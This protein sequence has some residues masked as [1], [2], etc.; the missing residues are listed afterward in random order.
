M[1]TNIGEQF[2][3]ALDKCFPKTNP[4]SKIL[5]RNTVKLNYSCMPNMKKQI[6]THNSRVQKKGGVLEEDI[7]ICNCRNPP[8]PLDGRCKST[9]SSVYKA[10][11]VDNNG[12]VETYTGA[13]KNTFKERYY[14]HAQSFRLKEKEHATT[15]SSYIWK[16]KEKGVEYNTKWSIIEKGKAFNPITR[17]CGLCLKEKYNIIF[18]PEGATLNSRSELFSTCRHRLSQLLKNT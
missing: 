18:Q 14:G 16:L 17:K 2:L 1:Q 13:T 9:K 8:C 12:H 15:L 4:L 5:N 11:V 7:P 6:S 10:T 3:K